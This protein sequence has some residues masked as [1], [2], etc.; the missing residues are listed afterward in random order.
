M[1]N[2]KSF[3]SFSNFILWNSWN[4]N[5]ISYTFKDIIC[6]LSC[7]FTIFFTDNFACSFT[8]TTTNLINCMNYPIINI[9]NHLNPCFCSLFNWRISLVLLHLFTSFSFLNSLTNIRSCLFSKFEE[10]SYLSCC[11]SKY[12]WGSLFS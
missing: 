9:W 8:N 11:K 2:K 10:V 4:F 12:S 3:K 1:A 7:I 5:H 6:S